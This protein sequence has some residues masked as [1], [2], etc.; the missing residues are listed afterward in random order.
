MVYLALIVLCANILLWVALFSRLDKRFNPEKML[1]TVREEVNAIILELNRVTDRN[2]T[3]FNARRQELR[4]LLVEIEEKR[5]L[6]AF[7]P[8][9]NLAPP[10]PAPSSPPSPPPVFT[11]PLEIPPTT[12]PNPPPEP[13]TPRERA[14]ALAH[15]GL[16]AEAIANHLNLSVTEVELYTL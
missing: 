1:E 9:T 4:A 14:L 16:T 2:V 11:L 6:L 3:L 15:Q 12:P 5:A 10:A 7:S 13:P 8:P